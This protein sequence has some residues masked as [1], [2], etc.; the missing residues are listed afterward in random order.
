LFNV[1]EGRYPKDLSELVEKKYIPQ[2]P[3]TPYGSKLAYDA[4]TGKVT[5]V[6]E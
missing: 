4:T 6:N 3:E 1:G 2:I 5:V